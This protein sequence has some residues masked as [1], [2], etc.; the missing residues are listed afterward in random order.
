[1]GVTTIGPV[2]DGSNIMTGW[3]LASGASIPAALADASDA[4]FVIDDIAG[5]SGVGHVLDLKLATAGISATA[6]IKRV[7]PVVRH[8]QTAGA[9][10]LKA[11]VRSSKA[12][13]GTYLYETPLTSFTPTSAAQNTSLG[14]GG[15]MIAAHPLTPDWTPQ[16]TADHLRLRL[17]AN[18]NLAWNGTDD[19]RI[20]RIYV[21]VEWDEQPTVSGVA[22]DPSDAATRTTSPT[23]IW[24]YSD[25]EGTPQQAFRVVVW[26]AAQ[27]ADSKC[28]GAA[29][30][31]FTDSGSVPRTA[32][33]WSGTAADPTVTGDAAT[34]L[35]PTV[36]ATG[37]FVAFVQ[38][39]DKVGSAVRWS[40]AQ[41]QYAFTMAV[42]APATPT[43]SAA[44]WQQVTSR[45]ELTAAWPGKA[46]AT[47]ARL[48][49]ER[50]ADGGN[51]WV[52]VPGY[53]D[54]VPIAPTS[55]SSTLVVDGSCRHAVPVRYRARV[56][57]TDD[58]FEMVSAWSASIGPVTPTITQFLLRDPADLVSAPVPLA[59]TGELSWPANEA[60]GVFE[61]IGSE[62]PV[63]VSSG[64]RGGA[65][66]ITVM[67]QGEAAKLA[68][69]ALRGRRRV[70]VLQTDMAGIAWWVRLGAK[71]V[72][73]LLLSTSRPNP[74][75]RPYRVDMQL[76]QSFGPDGQVQVP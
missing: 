7:T 58:V 23:L 17:D 28:P 3:R 50:S 73:T 57:T 65:T 29:A 22:F 72:P 26:P 31:S 67:V 74:A 49:V 27:A 53:G 11:Q 35:L 16:Y 25:P 59:L 10:T 2:V 70:L 13:A 55:A 75:V 47:G 42:T 18:T 9:A 33:V 24:S 20:Y 32:T 66:D 54:G 39:A 36:P 76:L 37:S 6:A 30:T 21:E 62:F 60:L 38:V 44:S 19:Q 68:L 14:A 51:T 4:T 40:T 1:M 43:L 69:D 34:F 63:Y 46:L 15:V 71:Y 48:F 5:T 61:P 56:L 41:G 45:V 52:P 64:I 8:L 12:V